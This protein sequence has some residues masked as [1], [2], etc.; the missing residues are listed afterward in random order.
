M[1]S[2]LKERS[3][4]AKLLAIV[5]MVGIPGIIFLQEVLILAEKIK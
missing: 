5:L 2:S 1:I 4:M 3:K